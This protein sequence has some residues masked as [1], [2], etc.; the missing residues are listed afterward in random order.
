M[1][2]VNENSQHEVTQILAALGAGEPDA[3]ERLIRVVYQ[4][5]R[6]LARGR[7]AGEKAGQS[8]QP[9]DLV[10][11]AFLRLFARDDSPAFENR[12]HFFGAAAKAMRRVL[13]DHAREKK[14]D[15]RGGGE[16]PVTLDEA[17][18]RVEPAPEEI[19]DLDW[20]LDQL[21]ARDERKATVVELRFFAGLTIEE[22]AAVLEVTP[23]TVNRD[24]LAA[25]AWL[26]REL[27]GRV[28]EDAAR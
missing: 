28:D 6:Q 10:H 15:K 12:R 21:A 17:V 4:E 24:W 11:E 18:G 25:R 2:V 20:A 9:T 22:T 5:L 1:A 19:L 16:A 27:D 8:L 26:K 13:V 14:A 7:L 3:Q 23:R